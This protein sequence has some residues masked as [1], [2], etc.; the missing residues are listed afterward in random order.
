MRRVLGLSWWLTACVAAEFERAMS[1]KF[2]YIF[3]FFDVKICCRDSFFR[4]KIVQFWIVYYL[5]IVI[6]CWVLRVIHLLFFSS[7]DKAYTRWCWYWFRRY[8]EHLTFFG[9]FRTAPDGSTLN[10]L[11]LNLC[12]RCRV[13]CCLPLIIY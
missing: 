9:R 2:G 4:A 13:C 10:G 6:L 12:L 1:R 3:L 11:K 5:A 7:R 8:W